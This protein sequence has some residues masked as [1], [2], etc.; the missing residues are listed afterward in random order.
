MPPALAIVLPAFDEA[1]NLTQAVAEVARALDAIGPDWEIVIVDDGSSDGTGRLADEI[2]QR[3]ARITTLRHPQNWGKGAALRT[4]VAAT[5]ASIVGYTDTDLPFDM[6]ALGRAYARLVE[7]GA[8]L[9]A[10]VRVNRERYSLRRRI[11]SGSYNA[12]VRA[13]LGLPL[14]DVGF[15][16]KMMRRETFVAAR[17]QSDG[18][19]VDVELMAR[20]L[21][22][23]GQIERIGVEFTPRVS[24]TS[25][26]AGP[27][28]VAG[29]VWDMVRFRLG[30]L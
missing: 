10:G 22:A 26:M 30:R 1:E 11:F 19:F 28:S 24:G 18:G 25:T 20:T 12:L 6:E 29:I 13:L 7:T 9:V 27:V 8:D 5:T 23:G 16:L 21:R 3:D 17:L 15:A 2:A 14:D 4:G